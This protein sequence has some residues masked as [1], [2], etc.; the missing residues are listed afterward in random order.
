MNKDELTNLG[1][2]IE[3]TEGGYLVTNPK[4]GLDKVF[5]TVVGVIALIEKE[6]GERE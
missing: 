6:F 1:Y 5:Y 3:N 2:T 4:R